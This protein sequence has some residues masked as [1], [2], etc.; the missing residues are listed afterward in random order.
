MY[1]PVGWSMDKYAPELQKIK[2]KTYRTVE[3]LK[4]IRKYKPRRNVFQI[5]IALVIENLRN[6]K[7]Y[8]EDHKFVFPKG[9]NHMRVASEIYNV[10]FLEPAFRIANEK[11]FSDNSSR[12]LTMERWRSKNPEDKA[13]IF[14]RAV[15]AEIIDTLFDEYTQSNVEKNM[16]EDRILEYIINITGNKVPYTVTDYGIL[17]GEPSQWPSREASQ[18]S[19]STP[20]RYPSDEPTDEQDEAY[21]AMDGLDSF[22]SPPND[23]KSQGQSQK[24]SPMTPSPMIPPTPKRKTPTI[25]DTPND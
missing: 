9:I 16:L 6:V 1:T 13:D 14:D 8:F 20:S 19:S 21:Y 24:P 23:Q 18:F 11:A 12:F 10:L 7:K 4:K 17:N 5:I 3:R 25:S 22:E 15:V 2:P